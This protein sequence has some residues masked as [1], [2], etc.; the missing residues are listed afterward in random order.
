MPKVKIVVTDSYTGSGDYDE[1]Q[2]WISRDLTGWQEITEDELAFLRKYKWD[3]RQL[4]V[5]PHDYNTNII[6]CVEDEKP[7]VERLSNLKELLAEKIAKDATARR[8]AAQEKAAR[9]RAVQKQLQRE[10]K[11]RKDMEKLAIALGISV[12]DLQKRR[13][14]LANAL[15]NPSSS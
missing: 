8:R 5:K 13:E 6:I 15:P 4:V 11:E 1:T 3:L 7:V 12:S 9:E 10:A 14:E 2:H